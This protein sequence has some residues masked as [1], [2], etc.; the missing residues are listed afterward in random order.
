MGLADK[1]ENIA[2][3]SASSHG[4]CA[5]GYILSTLSPED[6]QAAQSALDSPASTRSIHMAF[7]EEGHRVD[8]TVVSQHRKGFCRCKEDS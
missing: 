6:Q 7:L 4:L 8:R 1:L 3:R 2:A 5:F